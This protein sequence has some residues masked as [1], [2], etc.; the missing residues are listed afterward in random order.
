MGN[1]A[2]IRVKGKPNTKYEGKEGTAI[3]TEWLK[4]ATSQSGPTLVLWDGE[5]KKE[6][7]SLDDLNII[8]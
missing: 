7:V 2:L 5:T 4:L 6:M 3:K 8:E 1:E